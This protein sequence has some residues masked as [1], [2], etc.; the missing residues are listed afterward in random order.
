MCKKMDIECLRDVFSAAY[1]TLG[2]ICK[3]NDTFVCFIDLT[4]A[5]SLG[6]CINTLPDGLVFKQLPRDP[7]NVN[8]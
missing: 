5:G 2:K 3:T 8:A 4:L 7:A 1:A 6:R